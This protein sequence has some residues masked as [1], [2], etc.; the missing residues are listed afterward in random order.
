[1]F[2]LRFKKN[3]IRSWAER[4]PI[5]S[6]ERVEKVIAQRRILSRPWDDLCK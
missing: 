3:Q 1:M 5:E 2:S 6:D 4:Y